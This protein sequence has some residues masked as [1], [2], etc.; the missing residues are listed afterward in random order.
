[1]MVKKYKCWPEDQPH[2]ERVVTCPSAEDAASYFGSGYYWDNEQEL[3]D[4]FIVCVVECDT[5]DARPERF[6]VEAVTT[7]ETW[8]L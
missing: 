6:T 1:M 3:D 4:E 8:R 5:P 7:F 2:K